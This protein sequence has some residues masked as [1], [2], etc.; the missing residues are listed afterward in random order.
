MAGFFDGRVIPVPPTLA[1]ATRYEILGLADTEPN[2][3]VPPV[4]GYGLVSTAAGVRSW[5]LVPPAG[6]PGPP[7][8][9]GP[10]GG[11]GGSG[12]PGPSGPSGTPGTPGTPGP[13][14]PPGSGGGSG[15]LN[16][17][18]ID[19]IS[20]NGTQ[21]TFTLTSAGVN[22]PVTVLQQD[23]VLFIGGAIQLAGTA[24]T[25]NA[26]LSQVTFTSAPP[27][28]DYFVGWVA[29]QVAT[30]PTGPTGPTGAG[31]L[32]RLD[33]I[34]GG[35]NGS[36]VTFTLTYLGGT[37]LPSN[38]T[39]DDLVLFIGGAVQSTAAF[40]WNP[41]LSQVTFSTAP[42]AGD[43]FVGFVGNTVAI[44]G[45][46]TGLISMWSGSVAAIPGGWQL[47]DGTNGTPDLRDRFIVGAGSSYAPGN[48]GGQNAVTLGIGEMPSHTHGV[49]DPG[50]I[51][52]AGPFVPEGLSSV[53]GGGGI[54]SGAISRNTTSS[55][56]GISINA[57]GGNGA[58]ENRPPYYALAYIMCISGSSS[59]G[60]SVT[61]TVIWSSASTA[62]IGYVVCNGAAVSRTTYSNLFAVIGTTYGNGDGSTTFNL[63]DLRA[64]FIRGWDA[65][66]GVDP[67]RV[68]GSSQLDDF[69]S[70]THDTTYAY[71]FDFG[72]TGRAGGGANSVQTYNTSQA[73]NATGGTETR[74][75]NVALLP[76][77]KF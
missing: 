13:V 47:C 39:A 2:L 7:G 12:P 75:R 16:A 45:V 35:F 27:A 59:G 46:P 52:S 11:T 67:G 25:W 31:G 55:A 9:P 28:G 63:P 22:L 17:K 61:G 20:F 56:T 26:G 57:E 77:I 1:N 3:G 48:T 68:F 30:G 4:D 76:C 21:T 54:S 44:A 15:A 65:G 23:L 24:F 8:A 51:H 58:H 6:P 38:V 37:T 43:Y 66:R 19:S 40:S 10:T 74:P 72:S 64:E 14:G 33:N 5:Q 62:P 41:A 18:Y 71:G 70:H 34:S 32:E 42:P 53:G 60:G 36:T 29:S 73:I 69:E 50:H 49:S